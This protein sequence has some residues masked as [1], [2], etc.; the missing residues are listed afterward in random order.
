MI[1]P[2]VSPIIYK[3]QIGRALSANKAKSPVIFDIVNNFDN[4]YS[5]NAI[6]EEMKA[7]IN[8]YR[9]QGE[10]SNIVNESFTIAEEVKDWKQLFDGLS[11]TLSATWEIMY[12]YAKRYY[13][14]HGDLVPELKYKT[15]EGY[16]LGSWLNTQ[17]M[18]RRGTADGF[19]SEEQIAKLDAIGMRWET[20]KD[21]SWNKNFAELLKYKE[22][23]GNIDVNPRYKTDSGV[24]L[25]RWI[26][27][28]R[29][30]YN[31][32]I[33]KTVLTDERIAALNQLGMIWDKLDYIWESYYQ[34][35]V[36]YYRENGSVNV[37][38]NYRTD[39][40]LALGAWLRKIKMNY[41]TGEGASLTENQKERLEMLGIDLS[42]AFSFEKQWEENYGKAKQYYK[43]HGNMD[44]P[45]GYVTEDGVALGQWVM[46]VRAAVKQ[47]HVVLTEQMRQQLEDI[48]VFGSA[49]EVVE[50]EQYYAVLTEYYN[51][52]G[53]IQ[54]SGKTV[55]GNLALGT[56]L[57]SKRGQY[58]K[59]I[60]SE[61][62]RLALDALGM[63]W[64]TLKERQWEDSFSLAEKFYLEHGH[65]QVPYSFGK[66]N[67]WVN[68]QRTKHRQNALSDCQYQRLTAIG[69]VWEP[70]DA[71]DL[72]YAEAKDFYHQY[73][74][75]D[76]PAEYETEDGVR[77]GR[78][79]RSRLKEY[80]SGILSE[81]RAKL[82]EAIGI[83][84]ESV[85]KRNW[86][87]NYALAKRFYEQNG[88]LSI[89]HSYVSDEGVKLGIWISDQREKY[90]RG[91]LTD[92]QIALLE[93]IQMHWNR[94]EAKWESYYLLAENY[95]KEHGNLGI[96]S[97]YETNEGVKL[98]SWL[99]GQKTKYKSNKLS[100][101]QIDRLEKLGMI[102]SR[103]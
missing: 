88:N 58:R 26:S 31:A 67:A 93:A 10:G 100:K 99:C 25:G 47:K 76:I 66:L 56:W 11:E 98:G 2:T 97:T 95:Y 38:K 32:G 5:I 28:L 53:N 54:M 96:P 40:G 79:Y 83:Q 77:L 7:A 74:H 60:L 33:Q 68:V 12:S 84:K 27:R 49:S 102:W 59:G 85:V 89:E 75:L 48:G 46:R 81:E 62:E 13:D 91:G 39:D 52:H 29:M 34:A 78:W 15:E 61:K 36:V 21:C 87:R 42:Y 9:F 24:A 18:I 72:H 80:K 63:D 90:K 19:L 14:E 64:M 73:G 82:L 57:L 16:S 1:R 37:P 20:K 23:Y 45:T 6:E 94:F 55:Y 22:Q 86:M 8:Y 92:E 50:F 44:I 35:L 51:E 30:M 69:M 4:L 65:L 101:L 103:S 17:R 70:D 43:E 71:W 3:Q 41:R